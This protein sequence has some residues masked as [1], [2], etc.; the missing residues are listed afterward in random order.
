MAGQSEI[1]HGLAWVLQGPGSYT[2]EDTVEISCHG[3]PVLLDRVV[4]T[5]L[6][7]GAMLARPGEFTQRAY[8]NGRLDLAQ[9]EAVLDLIRA[10]SEQE[11]S[12]AY[13]VLTGELGALVA[14]VRGHLVRALAI[15]EAGL[16]FPED[17][18]PRDQEF[19]ARTEAAA[20]AELSRKWVVASEAGASWLGR[21]PVVLVGPPN[22]GKSTLLNRL[23]GEERAIVDKEPG[24][25]RDLVRAQCGW[26]GLSVEVVDTAGLRVPTSSVE[27]EGIRRA[28][29]AVA[30]AGVVLAVLDGSLP[31]GTEDAEALR[32]A[33][34]RMVVVVNK[35]DLPRQK[36]IPPKMLCGRLVRWISAEKGTGVEDLI[37]SVVEKVRPLVVADG[38]VLTRKRQRSCLAEVA[39][40]ASV[41]AAALQAEGL[42]ECVAADLRGA[43]A[44]AGAVVGIGVGDEVL[45]AIFSE[46]CIG[47]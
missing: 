34:E 2:G 6:G 1:D 28:Q 9:A 40:R 35:A 43:L 11:R 15:I 21:V 44:A 32:V 41:A 38:V 26:E 4:T 39:V 20:A 29:A 16:D 24:T 13:G 37:A 3:S 12:A 25:T 46:F 7:H 36:E 19:L 33:G 14:R 5:A 45:E 23:V 8:L 42:P 47:K 10:G 27:A 18:L 30:E 31:W 17:D 22:V